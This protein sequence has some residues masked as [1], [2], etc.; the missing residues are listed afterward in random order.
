M[1]TRHHQLILEKCQAFLGAECLEATFGHG[2]ITLR[3]KRASLL[4]SLTLL[5]DHPDLLFQQLVDICGVDYPSRLERFEV[6]YHLLSHRHNTRVRVK[7]EVDE[8]TPV[9]SS[10]GLFSAA[11]WYEREAFDMYGIMFEGHT[12]L[13]RILTDYGFVGH[14]LRKD[15]PLTGYVEVRYDPVHQEVRYGPVD[16]P[17]EY[18]DFDFLSPWQGMTPQGQTLLPG[19]EKAQS[20]KSEEKKHDR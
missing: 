3:L 13:R 12:D 1:D 11:D 8:S 5:R 9:P 6:V 17:Q 2:E 20:L 16:L 15:F 14:P 19:D 4:K 10:T 7:V 18:R